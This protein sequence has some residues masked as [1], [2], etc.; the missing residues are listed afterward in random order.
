ME[1][2]GDEPNSSA[3][4]VLETLNEHSKDMILSGLISADRIFSFLEDAFEK[5]D[6]EQA[7]AKALKPKR[8]VDLSAH[9]LILDLARSKEGHVKLITTN[10]DLL[11]ETAET[12]LP[13]LD[14]VAFKPMA[15]DIFHGIVH[16]H[17]KV[18]PD[19]NGADTN[20][21]ILSS[22][23][24]GHA[25][26]AEG[27]ATRFIKDIL[28]KYHVVFVG[29]S[30]DDPPVRYLLEALN[31]HSNS[32]EGV[33]AFDIPGNDAE[34]KWK[35]K[36]AHPII[37]ENY[38]ILWETLSAWTVR[39]RDPEQWH[40]DVIKNALAGPEL[41]EPFERGQ[42]AHLAST[43]DGALHFSNS[44][45][46]LPA[47][48][49]YVFDPS[50]RFASP[51]R[52]GN[53]SPQGVDPYTVYCLDSDPLPE[54]KDPN[55]FNSEKQI[56]S[57]TWNAFNAM[58]QDLREM[59]ENHLTLLNHN[60]AELPKRQQI[61]GQWICKV[62]DHPATIRWATFQI[63]L[64]PSLQWH[65]KREIHYN[66][67]I[68]P[69][70]RSAWQYILESIDTQRALNSSEWYE[71]DH[72]V[73]T[74]GWTDRNIRAYF[75]IHQPRI[76]VKPPSRFVSNPLEE[77]ETTTLEKL[78]YLEIEYPELDKDIDYKDK[79]CQ[80]FA[81]GYR[82]LLEYAISIEK[83]I[84]KDYMFLQLPPV[85]VLDDHSD[86]FERG[87]QINAYFFEYISC[88]QRLITFDVSNAKTEILHWRN[89][90]SSMSSRIIIWAAG[91]LTVFTAKEASKLLIALKNDDFWDHYHQRDLLLTLQKRWH[92]FSKKQKMRLEKMLLEG[93]KEKYDK[94][95][96]QEYIQRKAHNI[97]NR[98][99]WLNLQGCTFT[100]DFEKKSAMLEKL[101]KT[102]KADYALQ[103]TGSLEGRS[104][105]IK[106]D[107]D[108][109]PLLNEPLATL[110]TKA[111][112]LNGRSE[113]DPFTE[114]SPFQGLVA[115]KPLMAF[116]A[117]TYA[118][119]QHEYPEWAWRKF[120]YSEARNSDKL[121]LKALI[122]AR[123]SSLPLETIPTLLHP[124]TSWLEQNISSLNTTY[125][126][127]V[128]KVW[129]HII[130]LLSQEPQTSKSAITNSSR[131]IDLITEALNAPAGRMVEALLNDPAQKN[132][133][134]SKSFSPEWV[135]RVES[136]LSLPLPARQHAI[137][138][139][140]RRLHWLFSIDPKWTQE[141]L[142]D[143]LKN[144][145][146]K[147]IAAFWQGYLWN[148]GHP[149]EGIFVLLKPYLVDLAKQTIPQKRNYTDNL[150]A[151]LLIGWGS[152]P[153]NKANGE[154]YISNNEMRSVLLHATNTFR[155][156]I[157]WTLKRW[158]AESATNEWDR[159]V[160]ELM[161][162]V[163][164]KQKKARSPEVTKS[165]INLAFTKA[166]LFPAIADLV[167][168]LVSKLDT[169]FELRSLRDEEKEIAKTYPDK[170]L[171][172]LSLTLPDSPSLWPYNI[173]KIF[174]QMEEGN[175]SLQQNP[176][177]IELKRRWNSR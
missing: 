91:E 164:P 81:E 87:Y 7:I 13:E 115:Q 29:Y 64:H 39:A 49:L 88:L 5:Q 66:N 113:E 105:F 161:K 112:K 157:F 118:M 124:L 89:N 72:A 171:E 80:K 44:A 130:A 16:L 1:A 120:L 90:T 176:Q 18:R 45:I 28:N 85:N 21:F 54:K 107:A 116:R 77:A 20:G 169:R 106:T 160:L 4:K 140:A 9:H 35:Q 58:S 155:K 126:L 59:D 78:I 99:H 151:L 19:Y 74:D 70:F 156:T 131:E 30:A 149:F 141:N 110:L 26:L 177:L 84:Y 67:T 143:I 40:Q 147:D 108:P 132:F 168:P 98:I 41:L 46:P 11:F 23:S 83:E 53:Y 60:V 148:P 104:D 128:E 25:Y 146:E 10:F 174:E 117:L 24:F 170:V 37:C 47:E 31:H 114:N 63:N 56:P 22:S 150:A 172:L 138:M 75:Q 167:I 8:E 142:I 51:V 52:F 97:L 109:A 76:S 122:A 173:Q 166:S 119:K 17:G 111:K 135:Q 144:K 123:V 12:D 82:Q 100:F 92:E 137:V 163:W 79:Y 50:F 175:P 43:V 48:W 68:S 159:R 145:N 71:L 62:L 14:P 165:L 139:L 134:E 15:N 121:R 61:L 38:D 152:R 33:Y 42:I 153:G 129:N 65:I 154:R 3:R 136:L 27:W 162:D 34:N 69:V 94:E 133:S 158:L 95:D 2:L 102:W 103:A 127:Q 36:G 86:G 93:P 57:L 96:T 73:S 125:P 32:L 55:N 101:A 6:I